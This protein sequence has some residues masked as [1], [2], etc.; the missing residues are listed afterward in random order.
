MEGRRNVSHITRKEIRRQELSM[1][2]TRWHT[3]K[4]KTSK[5]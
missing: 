1:S 3:E 5:L 2:V 4:S